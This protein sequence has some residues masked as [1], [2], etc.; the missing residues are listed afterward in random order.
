MGK[1]LFV[2]MVYTHLAALHIPFMKLLQSRG[3]E[4]HVAASPAEGRKDEVEAIGVT[5]WGIPFVRSPVSPKKP[6]CLSKAERKLS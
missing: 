6:H 2:A 3:Y 1:L 5:C 4:V